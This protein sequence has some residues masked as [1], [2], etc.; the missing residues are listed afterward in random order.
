MSL[1]GQRE[2]ETQK[3]VIAFFSQELGYEYLGDWTDRDNRNIEVSLL[4]AQL[5]RRN[6]DTSLISRGLHE[7]GKA[8]ALGEGKSVYEANKETYR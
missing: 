1:V 7:S 8:A 4:E 5:K 6:I 3:R 2:K